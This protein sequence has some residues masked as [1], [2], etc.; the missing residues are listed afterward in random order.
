MKKLVF[1]F[2]ID[3]HKCIR[4]GVPNL[5]DIAD[6]YNVCFTFFLNM[7]RAISLSDSI[8]G[9]FSKKENLGDEVY[10]GQIQMMSA[11]KKLGVKDYLEAAVLNPNL[12]HYKRQVSR[13][14][15]SNCE[16]GIHGG[17]NHAIWH[18]HANEWDLEKLNAE[19]EW[20]FAKI[21]GGGGIMTS[22]LRDLLPQDG[23]VRLYWR[24][25]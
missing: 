1:R 9:L 18:K 16:V 5:L 22:A 3:T 2:D 24:K 14:L 4:D 12:Y 25:Y 6:Y 13:L 19:I 17:R 11:L 15:E 8:G 10:S 7:G 23:R 20:V 21:R